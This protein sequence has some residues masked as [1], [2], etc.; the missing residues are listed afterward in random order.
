MTPGADE[1]NIGCCDALLKLRRDYDTLYA[2][3]TRAYRT[4]VERAPVPT[5]SAELSQLHELQTE[6]GTIFCR[7]TMLW[8]KGF[9]A[10]FSPNGKADFW[11]CTVLITSVPVWL[12][13]FLNFRFG[14]TPRIAGP[15]VVFLQV[16]FVRGIVMGSMRGKIKVKRKLNR[17]SNAA[18]P[19]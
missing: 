15:P 2:D 5:K 9:S 16:C 11:D 18:S 10:T 14:R 19:I 12:A 17:T 1:V 13:N 4:F 7:L 3:C 8:H 6:R